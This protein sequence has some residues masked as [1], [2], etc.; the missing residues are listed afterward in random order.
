MTTAVAAATKTYCVC[1]CVCYTIVGWVGRD[2]LSAC[3]RRCI[4]MY[5]LRGVVARWL[6]VGYLPVR[7]PRAHLH[8]SVCVC[9]LLN[10]CNLLVVPTLERQQCENELKT[11]NELMAE[12]MKCCTSEMNCSCL[13]VNFHVPSHCD[14]NFFFFCLFSPLLLLSCVCVYAFIH[15]DFALKHLNQF[16][17]RG[18]RAYILL[19]VVNPFLSSREHAPDR[20]RTQYLMILHKSSNTVRGGRACADGRH[21]HQGMTGPGLFMECWTQC[22]SV[23]ACAMQFKPEGRARVMCVSMGFHLVVLYK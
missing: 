22:V 23:C 13:H 17:I 11:H 10:E 21:G 12:L 2:V 3:R 19:S 16:L 14:Y 15:G 9:V 7:V 6:H 20:V 1:V 5:E 8:M 18:V 4:G